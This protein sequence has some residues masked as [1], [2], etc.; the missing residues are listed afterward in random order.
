MVA[1]AMVVTGTLV[2]SGGSALAATSGTASHG[3]A[4]RAYTCSGGA[5][6]P[7]HPRSSTFEHIPSG[8]YTSITVTGF[9]NVWPGAKIRVLGNFSVA[10]G[11]AFDA[12]AAPATITVGHNFTGASGSIFALGCL[13]NPL[14][15]T[16]GHPCGTS[17]VGNTLSHVDPLTASSHITINGNIVAKDS[18]VGLLYGITVKRNVVLS[19][20]GGPVPIPWAIKDNSIGGNLIVRD[21]TPIWFGALDNHIGGNAI[22]L[23]IKITDGAFG[24]PNPTIFIASNTVDHNLICFDLGPAVAGG[25]PGEVNVVGGKAIGQCK[26]LPDIVPGG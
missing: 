4:P 3:T 9:C 6:N 11:A 7:A 26:N 22:L 2:L 21:M 19:G 18:N 13:P 16:T 15:H 5:L 17:L 1:G 10:A 14:G 24:D 23:N 25:F 8:T 20:G 12:Q